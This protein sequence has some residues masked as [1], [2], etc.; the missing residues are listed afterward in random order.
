MRAPISLCLHLPNFNYPDT[1]PDQ[2]F[3]R[4]VE[5]AT[6]AETSGFSSISLMDHLHQI[7]GVGRTLGPLFSA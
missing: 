5:I 1:E 7:P 2:V 4:L 6:V 3:E